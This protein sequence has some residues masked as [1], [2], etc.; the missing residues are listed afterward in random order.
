L[1]GA[2]PLLAPPLEATRPSTRGTNPPADFE[3]D[4]VDGFS[5]GNCA[6]D[7]FAVNVI[8]DHDVLHGTGFFVG[9]GDVEECPPSQ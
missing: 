7:Y 5:L 3:E 8:I 1:A 6:V 4:F 9:A 2:P